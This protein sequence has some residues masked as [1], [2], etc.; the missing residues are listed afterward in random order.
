MQLLFAILLSL[1]VG[2]AQLRMRTASPSAADPQEIAA[3]VAPGQ[4]YLMQ[5]AVDG[6]AADMQRLFPEGHLFTH[7]LLGLSSAEL[8]IALPP[9]S[10]ARQPAVVRAWNAWDALD[11]DEGRRPFDAGLDPPYGA[12]YAGWSTWLGAMALRATQPRER[13]AERAAR[14]FASCEALAGAWRSSPTPFLASYPHQVWPCDSAVAMAAL[15]ACERV[16]SDAERP[17]LQAVRQAWVAAVGQRLDPATGLLP[18][19]ADSAT[20]AP[21]SRPRGTSVALMA[22]VLPEVDAALARRHYEGLREHFL[23]TR[24]GAPGVAEHL[25]GGGY[26][27]I[28]S[29]P[30]VAGISL[31]ASAVAAGAA[32]RYGDEHLAA[33]LLGIGDVL[34]APFTWRGQRR[35]LFGRLPVADGFALWARTAPPLTTVDP[36]LV[37]AGLPTSA[38]RWAWELGSLVIVALAW[39]PV[40]RRRTVGP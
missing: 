2:Y 32:R 23:T 25:D 6:A 30:L 26:G 17:H 3:A 7:A 15:A 22:R 24:L 11:S 5:A 20:G 34:G 21:T 38:Q 31:S 10:P 9:H 39:V 40:L 8:A 18:H 37:A 13:S 29:G 33:A 27:D 28:D 35:Y 4:N 36:P 14:V 19:T 12:F 1:V 16:V